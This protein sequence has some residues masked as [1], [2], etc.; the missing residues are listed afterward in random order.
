VLMIT[1][2]SCSQGAGVCPCAGEKSKEGSFIGLCDNE[3]VHVPR[4][5]HVTDRMHKRCGCAIEVADF[6]AQGSLLVIQGIIPAVFYEENAMRSGVAPIAE[7]GLRIFERVRA[8]VLEPGAM[9]A[10]I[11]WA[12]GSDWM[13]RMSGWPV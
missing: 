5:G 12:F 10:T 8:Q 3:A 7:S 6:V 11:R 4:E 9:V 13:A 2:A 1:S